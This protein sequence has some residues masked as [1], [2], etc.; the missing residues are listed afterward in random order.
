MGTAAAIGGNIRVDKIKNNKSSLAGILNLE[1]PYAASV[2]RKT[3]KNVEPKPIAIEFTNRWKNLDGPAITICLLRT[4]F[5]YHDAGG[6]NDSKYAFGCRVLC[7]KRF[8]KP[9]KEGLKTSLGGYVIASGTLLNAVTTI[10]SSGMMVINT[11]TIIRTAAIFLLRDEGSSGDLDV[12]KADDIYYFSFILFKNFTYI[13]PAPNT[14]TNNMTAKAE[15]Y[16]VR[17]FSNAALFRWMDAN[18]VTEPGPPPVSSLT[19]S[20]ILKFSIPRNSMASIKNGRTEG[21]VI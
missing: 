20:N 1:K 13:F 6:G 7:V 4:I 17:H 21:R 5:S 18:S 15:L 8:T 19:M 16:P 11:Y 3:E 14:V 2:P 12:S 9:S 10:N